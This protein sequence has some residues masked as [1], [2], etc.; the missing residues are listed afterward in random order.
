MKALFEKKVHKITI[1]FFEIIIR[2]RREDYLY[3]IA[4]QFHN[5]Y[6]LDQGI[7]ETHITTTFELDA[8]LK[9]EFT[10]VANEISGKTPELVEHVDEEI[11]GGFI[12]RV[13]DQQLDSSI[14]TKLNDLRVK[15]TK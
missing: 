7:Q 4:E 10:K 12:L 3:P 6:N 15:L 8:G 2:K 11:V 14:R 1:S 9:N 13:A 5:L